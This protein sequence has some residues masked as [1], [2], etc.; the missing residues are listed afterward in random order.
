[1]GYQPKTYRKQGGDEF[2]VASGGTI[3]VE[4]GGTLK[5]AAGSILSSTGAVMSDVIVVPST[6]TLTNNGAIAN[7]GT[8]TNSSDGQFRELV[9]VKNT[10]GAI[11]PYGISVIGS[12]NAGALA[13]TML[14]PPAAGVRK[15]LICRNS[16]GAVIVRCSSLG[17]LNYGA[18]RKITFAANADGYML[19]LIAT[20]AT[21]WQA[22][23]NSTAQVTTVVF[24]TT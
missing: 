24:G 16:T 14:K 12:T 18:N 6:G 15:T 23:R 2:V 3:T 20:S 8:I 21:N 1:M 9:Q 10:A 13:Y 4:S 5:L 7:L 17:T 11:N 19:E 22:V